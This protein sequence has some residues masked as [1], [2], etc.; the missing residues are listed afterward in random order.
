[1]GVVAPILGAIGLIGSMF[2]G[3]MSGGGN[4]PA[5]PTAPDTSAQDAKAAEE[6]RQRRLAAAEAGK[7]N[8][9]GGL[10][11]D[12]SADIYKNTLG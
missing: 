10:G 4:M 8:Q 6:E 12:D 11:L 9:T 3:G 1:M 5:Q 7:T 2:S